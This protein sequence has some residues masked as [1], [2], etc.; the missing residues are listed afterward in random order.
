MHFVDLWKSNPDEL[1]DIIS[2]LETIKDPFY[3]VGLLR[4]GKDLTGAELFVL[5]HFASRVSQLLGIMHRI[6][7]HRFPDELVPARLNELER[8]LAP[9]TA[10]QPCFYVHDS[11][12][13]ELAKTRAERRAKEKAYRAEMAKE[14]AAVESLIGRR[15]ALRE[16]IAIRKTNL[17][18]LEKARLMPELGEIRETVTHVHFRL[19]ATDAAV[20]LER[21]I[22][23]LRQKEIVLEEDVL[24]S[25]SRQV[26][27]SLDVIERSATAVGRLD[28]LLAKA[29]F[30]LKTN[31]IKP[32]LA[33]NSGP[34]LLLNDAYHPAVREEVEARGGKYQPI[35]IDFDSVVTVV[36]GP[37]MGGKTV[38]LA[39]IGLCVILAQWG[40]LV[41]AG[42][43]EL[44][45]Y[46]YVYF[47]PEYQEKPGLSSFAVEIAAL[48]DVLGKRDLRGLI[49]LDEVGRGTNPAQGVALYAAILSYLAESDKRGSTV[50][51]T[52]HFH[53][54]A[55]LV[56][57]PHWQVAGLT[58]AQ[59]DAEG[60]GPYL[61]GK[62][63]RWLY[64][65]MDYRLQ[66]VGPSTP[67]PQDA[68]T[69]AKILGLNPEVIKRAECIFRRGAAPKEGVLSAEAGN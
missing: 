7:I 65:H 40:V 45:L 53:G 14:A 64:E 16:E 35:S 12:S 19:K 25:L 58:G 37:N 31:G 34:H 62:D 69:I 15:P 8:I 51:A 10:G 2:T 42:S 60:L 23:R 48:K 38:A 20:K 63:L 33:K 47:Q 46:D 44:S 29:E 27:K 26:A 68:I 6:G 39:T 67:I 4:E 57:A 11:Y 36:T 21:E 56:N 61:N 32:K 13:A 49:L 3:V 41:P 9:G 18:V 59:L 30:A 54:L 24:V 22:S 1:K 28:F 43:M 50:V 5:G 17:A 66:K 52:T 55:A